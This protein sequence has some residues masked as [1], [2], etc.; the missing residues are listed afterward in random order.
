MKLVILKNY[1]SSFNLLTCQ[2]KKINYSIE[3][4]LTMTR[5]NLLTNWHSGKILFKIG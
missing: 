2:P 1:Y 3:C 5:G 4:P